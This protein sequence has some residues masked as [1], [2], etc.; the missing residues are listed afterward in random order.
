[1]TSKEKKKLEYLRIHADAWIQQ[2]CM[3]RDKNLKLVK[4]VP[5]RQQCRLI[6]VLEKHRYVIVNKQRQNGISSIVAAIAIHKAMTIPGT[7]CLLMS[8]REKSV[9]AL[10]R[11]LLEI[12]S[13]IPDVFRIP[14]TTKN[15][16]ELCLENG[17]RIVCA[18]CGTTD[19]V[20]SDTFSYVHIS[21]AAL[22]RDSLPDQIS[23]IM[24]CLVPSGIFCIESTPQGGLQTQFA[25]M[26]QE[27]MNDKKGTWYPVFFSWVDDIG[28]GGMHEV[29]Q[30]Q[31]AE[32]YIDT[33]GRLPTVDE[34][35]DEEKILHY[36]KNCPLDIIAWRRISIKRHGGKK[37]FNANFPVDA[38][39]CFLSNITDSIFDTDL[40]QKRLL[41]IR[42]KDTIPMPENLPEVLVPWYG[43]GLQM[44]IKPELYWETKEEL[45]ERDK[46][47]KRNKKPP[48]RR[49]FYLGVDS[50]EG[51]AGKSDYSVIEVMNEDGEQC[52]E[53][54]TN[55]MKPYR[56]AE[57]INAL[58]LYYNEAL[59]NV[60]KASSGIAVLE[61]LDEKYEYFNLFR[62][63]DPEQ[64][65][66]RRKNGYIMNSRT[67]TLLVNSFA[68]WFEND[69]VTINSKQLL[70][71]M[72]AFSYKGGKME[73]A[74]GKDDTVISF[75]LC[76]MGFKDDPCYT[77]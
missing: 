66:A 70:T 64:H 56:L 9:T 8:Y 20:S 34:L 51:W 36:N 54:R 50:A 45:E 29:E 22:C 75:G 44:W 30:K 49:K 41:A 12:Y 62:S 3:I 73:A 25:E 35:D 24:G 11:K 38:E 21:E 67:K 18:V 74:T 28:K 37:K 4:F 14:H 6:K 58:G 47:S 76:I 53:F 7:N 48:T 10:W 65:G 46:H 72:L 68:Q 61:C 60:E 71:E 59:V 43:D 23:T 33:Y 15:K 42:D 55:K 32:E 26:Y 77:L 39:T 17:S 13:S 69:M 27:A 52:A 19:A 63:K 57:I 1:M 16:N 31:Y 2:F 40:V 5:N